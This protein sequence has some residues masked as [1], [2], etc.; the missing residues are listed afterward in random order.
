MVS[1][2]STI[3]KKNYE[4]FSASLGG[5]APIARIKTLH[6]NQAHHLGNINRSFNI[7][8][9]KA[10]VQ[11]ASSSR[12][13]GSSGLTYLFNIGWAGDIILVRPTTLF[14]PSPWTTSGRGNTKSA[15]S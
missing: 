2:A 14:I 5:K 15:L 4:T 11:D 9:F 3:V 12:R 8:R 7:V 6:L 10:Q 13:I 1:F